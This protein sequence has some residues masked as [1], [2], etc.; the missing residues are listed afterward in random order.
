MG[1]KQWT[2]L[3]CDTPH[4]MTFCTIV[5][6]LLHYHTAAASVLHLTRRVHM[7]WPAPRP[8]W[9]KRQMQK[10]RVATPYMHDAQS[11]PEGGWVGGGAGI[12]K[13]A[14]EG[15]RTGDLGDGGGS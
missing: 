6:L 14:C 2:V 13:R 4:V 8:C 3:L 7:I 12:Q 5:T 1:G 11:W 9:H 10:D 15:V